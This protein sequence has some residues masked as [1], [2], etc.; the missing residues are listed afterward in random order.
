MKTSRSVVSQEG[1]FGKLEP[2]DFVNIWL[3]L[4]APLRPIWRLLAPCYARLD[5]V[6]HL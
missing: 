1:Y 5:Y 6:K 3:V 2:S 4:K